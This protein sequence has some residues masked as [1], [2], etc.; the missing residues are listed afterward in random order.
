MPLAHFATDN[1]KAL[2]A[3][4]EADRRTRIS[5]IENGLDE[6]LADIDAMGLDMQLIM[7]PPPQCYYTVPLD[8]AVKAAQ[9]VNDGIAEYR[10]AASPTASSRSARVPLPDG[11]EAAKELE[12]CDAQARLQGRADPHQ[13][14]RQGTVRSGLRAVLEE[15]RGARRAG[16]DPP[17]RLHAGASVS[18]RFYFNNVIGNP[19]ETTI[20]LHYLIFD[21][22]LE[23]HPNL[24]ILAV[25][26]GGYLGGYAGRI[27]HAW[28]ARS[29]AHGDLPQSA[30]RAI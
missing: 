10:R 20:A 7:P 26:G 24:K 13:R 4:Q 19:L 30:D 3:K 2:N 14:Q 22:V 12:R 9:V 8:I 6:R 15:G 5:G 25:H 21:G 16:G 28:G 1:V 23:R 17:Q 27:D 29:D 11:N 18:S